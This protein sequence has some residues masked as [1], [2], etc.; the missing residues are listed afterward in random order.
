MVSRRMTLSLVLLSIACAAGW[1]LALTRPPRG[2]G[3]ALSSIS[4]VLIIGSLL[5]AARFLRYPSRAF[6]RAERLAGR[7]DVQGA[8]AAYQRLIDAG[9]ADAAPMAAFKLGLLLEQHADTEGARHAYRLAVF[10]CILPKRPR[11]ERP[12][13]GNGAEPLIVS[14]REEI[15]VNASTES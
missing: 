11:R 3:L 7:G 1:A 8:R 13:G 15:Q 6:A 5:A 2:V 12:G 4:A 14:V 9:H 10:S